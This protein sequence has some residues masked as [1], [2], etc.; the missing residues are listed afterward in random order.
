VSQVEPVGR[1]CAKRRA[2]ARTD[3]GYAAKTRR[4]PRQYAPPVVVAMLPG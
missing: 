1:D 2:P 3:A 4:N